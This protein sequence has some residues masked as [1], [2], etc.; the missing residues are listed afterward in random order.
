MA[1]SDN[2]TSMGNLD[3]VYYIMGD[4]GVEVPVRDDKMTP[5]YAQ[6]K[7]NFMLNDFTGILHKHKLTFKNCPVPAPLFDVVIQLVYVGKITR[8]EAKEALDEWVEEKRLQ[9]MDNGGI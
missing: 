2:S 1:N 8:I 3:Y 9:E 4:A 5:E 7:A 6:F